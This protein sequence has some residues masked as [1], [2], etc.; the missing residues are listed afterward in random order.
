MLP[1]I[2]EILLDFGGPLPKK[3]MFSE[4]LVEAEKLR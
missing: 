1:D 2:A 3:G 4:Q